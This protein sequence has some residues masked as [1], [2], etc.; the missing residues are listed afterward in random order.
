MVVSSSSFA[1][2]S[3][4]SQVEGPKGLGGILHEFVK[5][6]RMLYPPLILPGNESTAAECCSL[7]C[8]CAWCLVHSLLCFAAMRLHL[9]VLVK[10]ERVILQILIRLTCWLGL[11]GSERVSLLRNCVMFD[12]SCV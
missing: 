11:C 1:S 3:I 2:S 5:A 10:L 8:Y 4:S 6:T 7:L 9:I 12:G